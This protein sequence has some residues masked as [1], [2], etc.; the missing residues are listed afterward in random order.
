[1]LPPT[2]RIG[3]FVRERDKYRIGKPDQILGAIRE[4]AIG[5]VVLV[6]DKNVQDACNTESNRKLA[7]V[8][9]EHGKF[10]CC[11]TEDAK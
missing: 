10:V 4:G 1:M 8:L 11:V 2:V 5:S 3:C 6:P 9:D 7:L